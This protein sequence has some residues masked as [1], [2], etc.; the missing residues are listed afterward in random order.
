MRRLLLVL[1]LAAAVA[2]VPAAGSI[3]PVVPP[4]VQQLALKK[5]GTVAYA[6]TRVPFGYRYTSYT[7]LAASR[8]LTFRFDDRRYARNGKHALR[9][10]AEPFAGTLASCADGKQKT[11]Q[12]DGNKVYWDGGVAW[13]CVRGADGK[14]VKLLAAGP[15][16]P[17]VA[18]GIV[19]ASGKR[20]LRSAP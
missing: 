6:P 17:D 13:R 12:L 11:L 10:T 9:F 5:A 15:N 8:Q 4:F 18:L 3:K 19:A 16:L 7:W 1:S 14:L 20:I 2:A